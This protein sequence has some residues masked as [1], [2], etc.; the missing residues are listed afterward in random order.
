MKLPFV[1]IFLAPLLFF[2]TL[3]HCITRA[4]RLDVLEEKMHRLQ[5]KALQVNLQK[6]KYEGRL[7]IPSMGGGQGRVT[8]KTTRSE[9]CPGATPTS[10]MAFDIPALPT[11]EIDIRFAANLPKEH[12][13]VL[14]GTT[15]TAAYELTWEI[16][17]EGK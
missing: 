1:L 9:T 16:E 14:K 12:S 11:Q 15:K 4:G 10:E 5:L 17:V 7:Q 3:F 6:D 13:S 2:Y 8:R